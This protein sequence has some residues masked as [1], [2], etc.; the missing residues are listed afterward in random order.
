[1]LKYIEE[2]SA[3]Q[4]LEE[5]LESNNGRGFIINPDGFLE[6]CIVTGRIAFE[7][8]NRILKKHPSLRARI[9][10]DLLRVEGY[11]HDISKIYE[12]DRYHEI[13]TAYLTFTEGDGRLN[14]LGGGSKAERKKAL[15]EMSHIV[16]TDAALYEELG[17]EEF[18]KRALYKD[19]I[20]KFLDRIAFLRKRLGKNNVL[21]SIEELS[22][23]FSLNQFIALYADLT[24]VNGERVCVKERT[25][26]LIRR[27]NDAESEYYNPILAKLDKEILPRRLM[28]ERVIEELMR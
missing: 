24:N 15:T 2:E 9:N 1:M 20:G 19:C 12:G 17:R 4:L 14:L 5:E 8:A 6:H 7:V 16:L 23:P 10:P 26:E 25:E 22:L 28:V 21:L 27:Y 3:A 13:G 18:P 11:V